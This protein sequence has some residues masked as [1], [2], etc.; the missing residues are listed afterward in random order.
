M[1][2]GN[3]I[4]LNMYILSFQEYLPSDVTSNIER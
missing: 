3:L 1:K 4:D 2:L